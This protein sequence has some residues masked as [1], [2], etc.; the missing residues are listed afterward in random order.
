MITAD[1]FH[2][3]PEI[4]HGFFTRKNGFSTGLYESLNMGYGSSDQPE[5]ILKNYDYVCETLEL[6]TILTLKQV[7]SSKVIIV[8]EPWTQNERPEGDALVTNLKNI[9]LGILTADCGPLL[10]ADIENHI[11]GAAHLGRKGALLGLLENTITAMEE[12]GANR[13]HI[14]AALGPTISCDNYQ[15]GQD[16]YEEVLSYMPEYEYHLYDT[17]EKRKYNLD[18]SGL[19]A[20][21]CDEADIEFSD[22]KRCT[23]DESEL[24]FSY[25]RS[26]HQ[27]EADYGRLISVISLI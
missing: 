12:L 27:K 2:D 7:H 11:I 24:F 16:V 3:I 6:K 18:L 23:Y 8:T 9:G 25:R 21:L 5:N 13:N 15:V 20:D 14:K 17:T 19:I 4:K 22:I 1:I 10:L 26:T